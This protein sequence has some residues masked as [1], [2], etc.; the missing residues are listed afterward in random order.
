MSSEDKA[1]A[2]QQFLKVRG[3]GG[4]ERKACVH[5]FN[6]WAAL[7]N[8]HGCYV[9]MLTGSHCHELV[10]LTPALLAQALENLKQFLFVGV[11]EE[12]ERSVELFLQLVHHQWDR[13]PVY[14]PIS[15]GNHPAP[16]LPRK[17][18]FGVE[19]ERHRTDHGEC[20]AHL[21]EA[22]KMGELNYSDPFDEAVYAE[23][24]RMFR[25]VQEQ[26]QPILHSTNHSTDGRHLRSVSRAFSYTGSGWKFA[27]Q[28]LQRAIRLL[29]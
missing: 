5:N 22:M 8:S 15:H 24:Q 28:T 17:P 4:H 13:I 25:S 19:I 20:R 10:E 14:L 21:K 6:L 18:P 11:F 23:A 1:Q 2:R 7:P 3:G 26:Y 12:Y 16:T 27:L 9:K 29:V